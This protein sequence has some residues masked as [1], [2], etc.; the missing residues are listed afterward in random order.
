MVHPGPGLRH[1]SN[2]LREFVVNRACDL[3]LGRITRLDPAAVDGKR[4]V[5][6][7]ASRAHD[8]GAAHPHGKSGGADGGEAAASKERHGNRLRSGEEIHRN[9]K[10]ASAPKDAD[11]RGSSA[12]FSSVKGLN[13]AF[14]SEAIVDSPKPRIV[15]LARH[16][17]EGNVRVCDGPRDTLPGT[18][19]SRRKDNAPT[20][21]DGGCEHVERARRKRQRGNL[22]PWIELRYGLAEQLPERSK[23]ASNDRVS[24]GCIELGE[25][26]LKVFKRTLALSRKKMPRGSTCAAPNGQQHAVR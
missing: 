16:D 5:A 17:G 8:D 11:E 22:A 15:R 21:G 1:R 18:E 26:M 9:A 19:V 2:A 10:N 7:L 25:G 13:P 23:A 24:C 3:A 20:F 14:G 6:T 4:P 12:A